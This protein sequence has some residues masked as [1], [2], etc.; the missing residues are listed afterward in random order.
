MIVPGLSRLLGGSG[1]SSMSLSTPGP[2]DAETA[3]KRPD[4]R[5]GSEPIE[6]TRC[7]DG[8]TIFSR[9]SSIS[10]DPDGC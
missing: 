8:A 5:V 10:Y 6:S 4:A 7:Q 1:G 9:T 2:D 3:A